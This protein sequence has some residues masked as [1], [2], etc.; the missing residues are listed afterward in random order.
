[1]TCEQNKN[2][3]ISFLKNVTRLAIPIIIQNCINAAISST[4]VI[5]LG[6]VNDI[7]LATSSVVGQFQYLIIMIFFGINS[8]ASILISQYWG[9]KDIDSI[10]KIINFAWICSILVSSVFFIGGFFLPEI[11]FRFFSDDSELIATGKVYLQ[12]VSFSFL[13]MSITSIYQ[14]ALRCVGRV[15]IATLLCGVSFF[16]NLILN[17][18]LIY[19]KFGCP[20]LGVKGAA[21]ATL[22]ARILEFILLIFYSLRR[23]VPIK[24]SMITF[25]ALDRGLIKDF[26]KYSLPVMCSEFLW[27]FGGVTSIAVLGH[28][29]VIAISANSVV[30][31]VK[32]L[33]TIVAFG[34]A[35]TAAIILGQQIG[36]M[37]YK[38]AEKNASLFLKLTAII[39]VVTGII[40]NLVSGAIISFVELNPE[41]KVLL[42]K[43]LIVISYYI[44]AQTFT[45]TII[46][47][48]MRP[49]GDVMWGIIADL[50]TIWMVSVVCSWF[51]ANILGFSIIQVYVI[52]MADEIIKIPIVYWRYKKKK[53]LNN[54]TRNIADKPQ[55]ACVPE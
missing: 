44:V 54:I 4:D 11:V 16:T 18:L 55:T 28:M 52:I 40:I 50:S 51:A 37:N 29:G 36:A 3:L 21:V 20:E 48:I 1:M 34:V 22:V 39:G 14:N 46:I 38:L 7:A 9:K 32:Q 8:G 23:T 30:Q 17:Y 42:S 49:G 15:K 6:K 24:I 53:W 33:S 10:R 45:T 27:S 13:T 12:I 35:N 43:M 31:T 41:S 25:K 26:F 2:Y 19:G 47:G 5:M